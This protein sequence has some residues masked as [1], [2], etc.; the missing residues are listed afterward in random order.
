MAINT[1]D[2]GDLVRVTGTFTDAAGAAVDPT[3]VVLKVKDPL[4]AIATYIYGTDAALVKSATGVYYADLS[5]AMPGSYWAR[6][7]A[8]GTGQCAGEQEI[9]VRESMFT[10]GG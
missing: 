5:V 3:T 10:V 7:A 9:R 4:G 2:I 8:T 6:F 1:Y